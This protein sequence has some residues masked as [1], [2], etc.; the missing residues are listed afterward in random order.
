MGIMICKVHGRVGF[1]ETCSHVGQR[2]DDG[3]SHGGRRLRFVIDLY[4]CDECYHSLGYDKLADLADM[5]MDELIQI[6]KHRLEALE[7]AYQ[8]IEGRRGFC[9]ECFAERQR[10]CSPG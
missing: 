5:P 7:S 3:K 9:W 10:A 1:V 4:V 8:A 6:E 2:I